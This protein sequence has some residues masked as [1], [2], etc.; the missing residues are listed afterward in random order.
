MHVIW[1]LYDGYDWPKTRTAITNAVEEVEAKTEERKRRHRRSNEP[2]DEDDPIIGDCLF[3]SIYIGVSA[4]PDPNEL[5]RQIN[6]GI[7][8]GASETE[9]Y[10]TSGA[11]RPTNVSTGQQYRPKARPRRLKLDRSKA[12]KISFELK[13]VSA[14]I[15]TFAPGSGE[16]QSMIDVRIG[17]FEIFDNVPTSTWRKFLT[18]LHDKSE[19][20]EMCKPLMHIEMFNVRPIRELSATEIVMRVSQIGCDRL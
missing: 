8:D 1:N 14:D 12:H 5:R 18:S 10:Q 2:E 4:N 9:S 7:N 13:G 20:R 16:T 3:N 11:S 19:M 6:Q 15:V 17:E